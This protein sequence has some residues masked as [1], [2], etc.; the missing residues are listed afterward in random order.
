MDKPPERPEA[1]SEKP[2][3]DR[4]WRPRAGLLAVAVVLAVIGF[5]VL[6]YLVTTPDPGIAAASAPPQAPS[7]APVAAG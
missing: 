6:V 5:G 2:G 7:G 3:A 4:A 1:G